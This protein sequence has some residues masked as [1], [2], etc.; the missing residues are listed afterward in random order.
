MAV[1]GRERQK[2]LVDYSLKL[3]RENFM[4]HLGSGELNYMSRKEN[5]FS[6]KFSSFIHEGNIHG[7][8]DSF[9]MAGNH[10]EANGN[11]RII[12]MDLSISIIRLLM[13]KAPQ[14]G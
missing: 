5:E 6:E 11:P 10:I 9:N 8:A 3:L 13:Q 14:A 4:L 2:Q 7:L 1:L 12:F